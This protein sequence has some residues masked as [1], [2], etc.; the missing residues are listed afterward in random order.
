MPSASLKTFITSSISPMT[1]APTLSMR[2]V[3]LMWER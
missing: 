1:R 3:V 2:S